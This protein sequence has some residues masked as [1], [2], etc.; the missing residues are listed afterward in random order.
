MLPQ[1]RTFV[2]HLPLLGAFSAAVN[3]AAPAALSITQPAR[4]R[5]ARMTIAVE[6]SPAGERRRMIDWN[7]RAVL[8]SSGVSLRVVPPA[9]LRFSVADAEHHRAAPPVFYLQRARLLPA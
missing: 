9:L 7:C 6:A 2:S 3:V 8:R 4:A 1:Q 5:R